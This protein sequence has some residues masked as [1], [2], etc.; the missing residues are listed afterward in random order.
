MPHPDTTLRPRVFIDVYT[1]ENLA[2]INSL[3]PRKYRAYILE[4]MLAVLCHGM[5]ESETFARELKLRALLYREGGAKE[6][7]LV[8]DNEFKAFLLGAGWPGTV[9]PNLSDTPKQKNEQEGGERGQAESEQ[10]ES[11]EESY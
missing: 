5:T 3:V 10:G 7:N 4:Y 6:L 1:K 8:Y 2:H 11:Q 9:E